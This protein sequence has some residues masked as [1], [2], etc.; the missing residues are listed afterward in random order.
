M[1]FWDRG[2]KEKKTI[3]NPDIILSPLE[4]TL[5]PVTEVN[6]PVFSE[7]VIGKSAAVLPGKGRIVSPVNGE[8]SLLFHTKHAIGMVSDART[9]LMIHIGLDTVKLNGKY[10]K[11]YVAQGD[12]VHAGDLLMEF[13][14]N[15]MKKLGFDMSTIV[16]VCNT[17]D[18]PDII[19]RNGNTVRELDPMIYLK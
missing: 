1:G 2:K 6:D 19:C 16:V 7:E 15:Q 17:K 11:S 3:W 8:I 4:G 13:D 14:L 5:I 10:F 9:E 18:Y 12:R